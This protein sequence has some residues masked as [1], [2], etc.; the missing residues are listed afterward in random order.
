M[1]QQKTFPEIKY[2]KEY[3]ISDLEKINSYF[4]QFS[5]LEKL[6]KMLKKL[7]GNKQIDISFEDKNENII[8]IFFINPID[9]E[10]KIYIPLNKKEEGEKDIIKK[11]CHTVKELKEENNSMKKIIQELIEENKNMK[12]TI[13]DLIQKVNLLMNNNNNKNNNI[14]NQT[15]ECFSLYKESFIVTNFDDE[16]LISSWILPRGIVK[17][18]RIYRASQNGDT[19]AD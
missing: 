16:E 18:K 5:S 4:K 9:E 1:I 15:N 10:E 3:N 17:Y 14:N 19:I 6:I 11:L 12:N 8:K 2:D 7:F 13:N